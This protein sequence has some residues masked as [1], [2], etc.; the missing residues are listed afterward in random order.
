MPPDSKQDI[1]NFYLHQY[2]PQEC[3]FCHSITNICNDYRFTFF[4]KCN[5]FDLWIDPLFPSKYISGHQKV[6]QVAINCNPIYFRYY[7]NNYNDSIVK[8]YLNNSPVK[9]DI[10]LH[11]Q[12]FK[13]VYHALSYLKDFYTEFLRYKKLIVLA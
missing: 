12:S 8:V 1:S 5:K 6:L 13:D 10:L 4:C 3:P 2:M 7:I 9:D 11:E